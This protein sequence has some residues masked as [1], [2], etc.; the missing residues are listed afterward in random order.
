MNSSSESLLA[1]VSKSGAHDAADLLEQASGEDAAKVL[2]QLNP[3]VA[4]QVLEEM[5]EEPR[6]VALTFAPMDKAKQWISNRDHPEDSVGWLMEP[7]VAVFKPGATARD[8][9]EEVRKLA[10]KAFITYGYVTDDQDRLLGLLVMRDL[11]LAEPDA[12]LADVMVQHPFTLDPEMELTDAMKVVVNKHYPVYPVCDKEGVLLGLVR[13]QTLFEAR[14]IEISAQVGSMVGVKNEERLST[15]LLRSLRFRH[16]WLQINL[17]TCFV[18]AAVVGVFQ[19]TL[20]R[21]V[22]LAVFLPVLAGQSGNTG[23]QALAVAL[24]G[25]TLGDLKA[26]DERN[27]VLKEGLLGLLNGMLVGVSAGLGMYVYARMEGNPSP[28]VLAVVVWLAMVASCVVSGLSG[29]LIPLTLRKFGADPATAS[30]I[31][32]TTATDV[33]SMGTFLG[34]ATLLVP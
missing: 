12:K 2:Q 18:A 8:T 25:M 14:A 22:L 24:R 3:M 31:F 28:G 32:L 20:D 17:L 1:A 26:G 21:L 4:Q 13:G 33:I 11:M 6:T 19:G 16:P 27:L 34:L 10:K 15:P 29:A 5:E 9:I 30:S 23:C 7:P